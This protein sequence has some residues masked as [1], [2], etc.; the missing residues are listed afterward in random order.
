M[1]KRRFPV[2]TPELT[3]VL[4]DRRKSTDAFLHGIHGIRNPASLKSLPFS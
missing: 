4:Y 1:P 2:D 3:H